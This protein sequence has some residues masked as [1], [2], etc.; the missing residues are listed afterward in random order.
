MTEFQQHPASDSFAQGLRRI[1]IT[2]GAASRLQSASD[3]GLVLTRGTLVS[4]FLTH[5]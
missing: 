5:R 1:L 3:F 2:S 4:I